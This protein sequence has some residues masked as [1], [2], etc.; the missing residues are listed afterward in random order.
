ML[1]CQLGFEISACTAFIL[2]AMAACGWPCIIQRMAAPPKSFALGDWAITFSVTPA[3]YDAVANFIDSQILSPTPYDLFSSNCTDWVSQVSSL[4]GLTLPETHDNLASLVRLRGRANAHGALLAGDVHGKIAIIVDDLIST[5][6]TLVRAAQAGI[7]TH[8]AP[9]KPFTD[10][11][12]SRETYDSELAEQVR[13]YQPDLLVLAGWMHIFTPAFLAQFA[14]RVINLHPA[15]PGMLPGKDSIHEAYQRFQQGEITQS[16]CMV[17]YV[18]PEVDAGPV[19]AQTVVS[20]A[21]DD[22]QDTF[23]ARMHAAEHR[24]IVEAIRI[25]VASK[26]VGQ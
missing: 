23:A 24:L 10:A 3:Q 26:S 9:L 19:I 1:F 21:P 15:L 12:Q 2:N 20:F 25:A 4:A 7:A 13:S 22:T 6:G 17:H 16:G 8:Y 14:G 11:G 18:V 5:G